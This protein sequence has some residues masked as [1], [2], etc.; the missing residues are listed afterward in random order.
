MHFVCKIL[1]NPKNHIKQSTLLFKR[2]SNTNYAVFNSIGKV[3]HIGELS[4]IIH[5]LVT[6]KSVLLHGLLKLF[7]SINHNEEHDEDFLKQLE[8]CS[9]LESGQLSFGFIVNP[10]TDSSI[11][12]SI[13][14]NFTF[15]NI[16]I[17]AFNGP[18]LFCWISIFQGNSNFF[19][20]KIT[21]TKS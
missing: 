7:Y 13:A 11:D 4:Q 20:S 6:V 5:G 10:S 2:W 3:V 19:M 21:Q 8:V 9:L 1:N 16:I 12:L 15:I 17:E 14:N 18:F